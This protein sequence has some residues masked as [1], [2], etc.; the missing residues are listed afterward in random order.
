MQKNLIEYLWKTVERVPDKIAIDDNKEQV[1]FLQLKESAIK[2]ATGVRELGFRKCPVGVYI[3]KSAK[4]I[5][6]F[7]GISLSCNFYVPLDTKSPEARVRSILQVLGAKVVIT[8]ASL[9]AKVE[10]LGDYQVL[11]IEDLLARESLTIDLKAF[12]SQQTDLDPVYAMFTSGSTGT[13]NGVVISHRSVIDFIDWMIDRFGIDGNRIIGNQVPFIFDVSVSDIYLMFATGSTLVIIPEMYFS[14]PTDLIDFINEKRINFVFWVPF[15]LIN[16]AN[17]DIF[18]EKLPKYLEDVFFAGEVM[19]N[20]HLNYWRRY[21]PQC[22]YVN[23]Y[24]PTEITVISTYYEVDREFADEESLPIGY[25]CNNCD[26]YILVDGKREAEINEKGELAIAG[27]GLALGYYGN[28][29]KTN[30]AFVQNPL[31]D[32]YREYVYLTGDI[33]YRNE[34]GEIIYCGRKDSQVKHNGYRIELGEIENAVLALKMVDNCCVVYDHC[35][36]KII[37]FYEAKEEIKTAD[38]RKTI[39]EHIPK[40]MVPSDYRWETSMKHNQNGK[41]DRAYY[42]NQIKK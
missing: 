42:N 14:F 38:F 11:V 36:R 1:T 39:S 19:P 35:N 6:A 18:S 31:N 3:P 23:L 37:L 32:K 8:I 27:T 26:N 15:V 16:A 17:V 24:G 25:A 7:A 13:P 5:E 29:E 41:I 33:C 20:R 10:S 2:I 21:L 28:W 34:R 40:Y 4:V 9:K 30:K 12:I 22:R